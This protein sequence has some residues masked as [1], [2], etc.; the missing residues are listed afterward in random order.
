MADN[1]Q[2]RLTE[3]P[4]DELYDDPFSDRQPRQAHFNE[5]ALSLPRPY[6][7]I[8]DTLRDPF[9]DDDEYVEKQPLN[10]GQGFA[11]G[12]YPPA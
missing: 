7:S 5:S 4:K 11:G 1:K 8:Q 3:N 12:F 6:E 10:V 2:Y 9:D